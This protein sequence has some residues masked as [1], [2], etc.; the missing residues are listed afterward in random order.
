MR[1]TWTWAAPTDDEGPHEAPR[2]AVR[3]TRPDS[4]TGRTTGPTDH[5]GG[6]RAAAPER[7]TDH[8]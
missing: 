1:T 4:S 3:R 2:A 5:S 6:Q 8:V 7:T